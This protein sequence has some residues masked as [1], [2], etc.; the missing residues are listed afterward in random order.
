M[1]NIKSASLLMAVLLSAGCASWAGHGV[2][3]AP[4]GKFRIAVLP[5]QSEVEVD[6]LSDI[7]TVP[8]GTG[9][10]QDEKKAI[11]DRM[12]LIT[13][14]MT[15]SIEVRLSASPYFT[16]I[17]A[18]RVKSMM[19][20]MDMQPPYPPFSAEQIGKLCAPL[21]A[22]VLLEV[23][24]TGYGRLKTR[25]VAY[26]IGSGIVEG[27]VEGSVVG[28]ATRNIWIGLAVGLQEIGQ[29]ILTWGGG[30]YLFNRYY[31]PVTLEG[32][33]FSAR[34]GQSVWNDTAFD[35]ID[36]KALKKL[37]EE[38]RSRKEVQLRVT[39]D[40]VIQDLTTNLEKAAKRNEKKRD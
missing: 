40:K 12:E 8:G 22:Q 36:R 38:E 9:P 7:E 14:D 30:A 29:E 4:G 24:L 26:L 23:R 5:V 31:A 16:V 27:V 35:S 18:S 1:T 37:P 28:G 21:D 34:D 3:T 25:W 20:G 11:H 33:L 39:A 10:V 2:T 32:A 17:P 13:E 19:E 15:R 6:R